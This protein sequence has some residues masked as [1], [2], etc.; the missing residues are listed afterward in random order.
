MGVLKLL[1]VEEIL[2]RGSVKDADVMRLRLAYYEDAVIDDHEADTLFT[3]NDSCPVQ[4]AS[5]VTFFIEAISD[6]VV[7]QSQPEGYVTAENAKWLIDRIAGDGQVDTKTELELL[8]T[9]LD[10]SR[11]S[12]SS[13][14]SFALEQVKRAVITGAGP[15]RGAQRIEKGKIADNEV[16][17]LRRI[18]YSF[19]GDG[20]VAIT[21]AEAEVL[22]D[23]NDAVAGAGP[24]PAWTDLFVKAITNV[25]MA[26][27]GYAVPSREAALAA[28]GWLD[29]RGELLPGTM[30]SQ[31]VKSGLDGVIGA[32]K[33][34]SREDRALARLERQRIEL[35]TNEQI[36][37]GEAQWLAARIGRNGSINDN[38]EA[39]I[40][41]L[42]A[43]SPAIH[44]TL[45]DALRK[46]GRAA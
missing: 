13:L 8:V 18:L 20:N 25:V 27:S 14:V 26:S 1:S 16:E 2:K 38:E 46:I 6:H 7:M 9:V 12:P 37:E 40:A 24:N 32:Y 31:M 17:L 19:G 34:Q 11:W 42:K 3:I 41:Y 22:F 33:E 21:R 28:E 35:I 15:L 39:L 23:I 5:W 36:T 44:P 10:R 43:E 30:Q 29:R 45:S 4:D